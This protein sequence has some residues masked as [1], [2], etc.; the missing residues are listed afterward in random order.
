MTLARLV[1]LLVLTAS[2]AAA[3]IMPVPSED[4][5]RLQSAR[6]SQGEEVLLTLLPETPLT[7]ILQGDETITGIE[8]DEEQPFR[9]RVSSDRDSFIVLATQRGVAGFLTVNTDRRLYRFALRDD[10][11]PAGALLVRFDGEASLE[12]SEIP[13]AVPLGPQRWPYRLKGDQEV[14]P[15]SVLDDGTKTHVAFF[16]RQALPAIF[17]IGPTGEEEVVNGYMRQGIYVIDRVY[18]ELV[19][20]IDK[21]KATATRSPQPGEAP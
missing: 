12:G 21:E 20:R 10:A 16:E 11:G 6:F 4:N 3:Q 9:V 18:D 15:A 2:P 5:P 13:T 1:A 14:R 17:A 19:F 8:L 7:V